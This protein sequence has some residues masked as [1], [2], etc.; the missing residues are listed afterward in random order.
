MCQK[1][2]FNCDKTDFLALG[3]PYLPIGHVGNGMILWRLKNTLQE[4]EL[5]DFQ[6]K[7]K[8]YAHDIFKL[9][10]PTIFFFIFVFSKNSK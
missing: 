9:S 6:I 3:H 2:F 1:V 10:I 8:M 5:E 4:Y 7:Q